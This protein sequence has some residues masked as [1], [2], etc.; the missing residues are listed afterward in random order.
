[1]TGLSVMAGTVVVG[2]S[3]PETGSRQASRKGK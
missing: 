1:M 3:Q 2:T